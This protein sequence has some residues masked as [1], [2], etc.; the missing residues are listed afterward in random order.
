MCFAFLS[1]SCSDKNIN[2]SRAYSTIDS[3]LAEK[4][5]YESTIIDIGKTRLK[6]TK[7]QELIEFYK[8]LENDGYIAFEEQSSKKRWLSKDSVWTVTLKLTEKSHPYV[9]DQRSNRVRLKTIEYRLDKN[10]NVQIDNKGKKTATATVLLNKE[11]TPF[12]FL[13]KDKTPNTKF[14]TKKFK[15]RY[16]EEI[17]WTVMN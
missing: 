4:P 3:Y 2:T 17:G 15:L 9:I 11:H 7:D 6:T 12:S 16:S 14:I 10:N 1:I 8:N 13:H 5:I